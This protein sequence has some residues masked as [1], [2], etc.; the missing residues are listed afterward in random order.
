MTDVK[1][2]GSA[3]QPDPPGTVMVICNCR[4]TPMQIEDEPY[5][6]RCSRCGVRNRVRGRVPYNQPI[7]APPAALPNLT[8]QERTY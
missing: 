1:V 7:A 5:Q 4:T 6:V 8:I 3:G 2:I